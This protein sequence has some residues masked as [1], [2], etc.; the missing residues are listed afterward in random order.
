MEESSI[1]R[2]FNE[3]IKEVGLVQKK[4]EDLTEK[5]TGIMERYEENHKLEIQLKHDS[6]MAREKVKLNVGGKLFALSKR[7]LLQAKGSYFPPMMTS[8]LWKP[9]SDGEY[10]INRDPECFG[11][12]AEYLRSREWKIREG[13]RKDELEKLR[14]DI[15]YYQLEA[16]QIFGKFTWST[17]GEYGKISESG[18][19]FTKTASGWNTGC[20]ASPTYE[21]MM[22]TSFRTTIKF[23]NNVGSNSVMVG[24]ASPDTFKLNGSSYSRS[25][26]YLYCSNGCLY[27]QS[28]ESDKK[29]CE[30]INTGQAI[31]VV[32][33]K[34]EGT[35]SFS[36]DGVDKG[37]AYSHP[38]LKNLKHL[39]PAIEALDLGTIVRII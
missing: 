26:W 12:I 37:V 31:E 1:K 23:E 24:V 14:S 6:A 34:N 4:L 33:N 9:D 27:S 35:L 18:V 8:E 38:E 10:F 28:G 3:I 15:E 16:P 11:M 39:C 36:V 19:L 7:D 5:L 29:Y 25:G 21:S 22:S 13:L 30:P 17:C 2:E 32:L 20:I